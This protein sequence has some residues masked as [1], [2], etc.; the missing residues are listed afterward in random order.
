MTPYLLS[1]V[2]PLPFEGKAFEQQQQQQQHFL[3][4][5]D[6]SSW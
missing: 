6:A 4:L 5:V 2:L 3:T 1:V